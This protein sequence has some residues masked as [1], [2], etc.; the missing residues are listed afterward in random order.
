MKTDVLIVGGGPAAYS[1]AIMLRQLGLQALVVRR[2]SESNVTFGESLP[3]SVKSSLKRLGLW[4]GFLEDGHLPCYNSLSAWGSEILVTYSFIQSANGHGW[5]IDRP[6]FERRMREKARQLGVVEREALPGMRLRRQAGD[7]PRRQAADRWQLQCGTQQIESSFVI[8]ASGRNSWVG[9]QLGIGRI[10]ERR[11]VGLVS[12]FKP[13]VAEVNFRSSLVESVA[14]GWWYLAYMPNGQFVCIYFT[15]ARL[16]GRQDPTV[17][18]AEMLD[19]AIHIRAFRKKYDG[20]G[21][22]PA[23]LIQADSSRL[24]QFSAPG[25]LAVGD[26]AITYHPLASHGLSFALASGYDGAGQAH[27]YLGGRTEA[28]EDYSNQMT[29][30]FAAYSRELASYFAAV[31]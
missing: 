31:G 19:Q 8:D 13:G 28:M 1:C 7:S 15:D 22:C 18:M 14:S 25:W 24:S 30:A 11:Q 6:L 2:S 12:F 27:A 26:A 21:L 16:V 17:L 29:K 3:G 10:V 5:H 4:Q 20:S 23:R 9:R